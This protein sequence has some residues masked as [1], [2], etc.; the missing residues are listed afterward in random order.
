MEP[1]TQKLK[2]L[3]ESS[4]RI[5]I[6]SHISPDPDAVSSLLLFGR[7][8]SLNYPGK[9][10]EMA[11]EEEP[12]E[13]GFLVGHDDIK[14]TNL[15]DVTKE[16]K[17]DLLVILDANSY[18]RVSRNESNQLKELVSGQAIKSA[19]ID[20]HEPAGRDDTDVY[21]N[22]GSPAVAQDVYEILFDQLGY[23]KPENYVQTTMTGIYSDTGGF[24][25]N[26]PRHS[27]TL[28][29]VDELLS[30]GA[31][32]E[33]VRNNLYRYSEKDIAVLA[34]LA[35][36]ASH[37]DDYN[38]SFI[39]DEFVKNWHEAGNTD[40]ELNMGTN[41]FVNGFLRN[42][43][44]RKWGFIVYK[45]LLSGDGI[46]SVSFRAVSGVKDVAEIAT[47]LGGG[48]HKPAAGA[49]FQA[50]SVED[51]IKKIKVLIG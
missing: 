2:Q 31:D 1:Q 22:Q 48:G 28:K 15:A 27:A 40:G 37:Q 6:T 50:D 25:Y 21:I 20:H 44:G 7:T 39:S 41:G 17:P 46:Y 33:L 19:I 5:L 16:F 45:N 32:I 38:Y 23:K 24:A 29:L 49:K 26:N 36:N 47:K 12:L 43:D 9:N 8:L 30:A 51:A 42:I 4:Q 3:I 13:V 10:I 14:I 34:E 35:R 11:L 18:R